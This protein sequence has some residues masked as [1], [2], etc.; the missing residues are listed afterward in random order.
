MGIG[1]LQNCPRCGKVFV[2]GTKDVCPACDREIEEEYQRCAE[3][4]R[5]HRLVNLYELSEATKVSVKQITKFIK[6]GRI[7][8]AELP[9]MTYPCESCGEPIREG[10]LCPSCRS[11]LEKGIKQ[12]IEMQTMKEEQSKGIGFRR[13]FLGKD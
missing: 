8:I 7:S 13:D 11:R 6:E 10:K 9:N 3:Y 4:I 12:A 2:K 1:N 5:E